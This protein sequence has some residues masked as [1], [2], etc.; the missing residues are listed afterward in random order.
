MY[1]PKRLLLYLHQLRKQREKIMN[2]NFTKTEALIN[3]TE[4]SKNLFIIANNIMEQIMKGNCDYEFNALHTKALQ[5]AKEA[6]VIERCP[7]PVDFDNEEMNALEQMAFKRC[8]ELSARI[9]IMP[10]TRV[11]TNQISKLGYALTAA[12]Q[13]TNKVAGEGF[14]RMAQMGLVNETSEFFIFR[15]ARNLVTPK[16]L[17][18]VDALFAERFGW[19]A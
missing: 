3:R 19:A 14:E 7:A 13:V 11:I 8:Y 2:F 1:S 17:A 9:D 4:T 18:K 10:S 12:K 5:K 15:S 6:K 16:V